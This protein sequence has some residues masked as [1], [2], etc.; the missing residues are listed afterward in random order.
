MGKFDLD[1]DIP[2]HGQ[3]LKN[4][5]KSYIQVEEIKRT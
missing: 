4:L 2:A 5:A 3:I 1:L